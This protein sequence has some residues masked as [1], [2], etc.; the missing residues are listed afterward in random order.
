MKKKVYMKHMEVAMTMKKK[1]TM[2]LTSC[3]IVNIN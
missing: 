2:M 1:K 3:K